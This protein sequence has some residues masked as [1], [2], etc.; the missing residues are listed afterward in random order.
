MDMPNAPALLDNGLLRT[1]AMQV[2]MGDAFLHQTRRFE[3]SSYPHWKD[4]RQTSFAR[5]PLP[6]LKCL[7]N[8]STKE[9]KKCVQIVFTSDSPEVLECV[10]TVLP[11]VGIAPGLP[12]H[13]QAS[14]HSDLM[15]V[16]NVAKIF[17]DWMLLARSF[18]T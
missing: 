16:D 11:G 17:V 5:D 12:V 4:K 8:A 15:E 9:S 13:P 3:G 18:V 2:R 14:D 1:V 7:M 6:T 10:R